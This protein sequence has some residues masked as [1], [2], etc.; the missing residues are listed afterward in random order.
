MTTPIRVLIDGASLGYGIEAGHGRAGTF[1]VADAFVR[2]ALAHPGLRVEVTATDSFFREAQLLR[3][4][5][6]ERAGLG[7]R[8]RRGWQ[9]PSISHEDLAAWIDRVVEVGETTSEGRKLMAQVALAN[10]L[11][12]P[13]RLAC[14]L[15]VYYSLRGPLSRRARGA[16]EACVLLVHDVI[17]LLH[18]EWCADGA[19]DAMRAALASVDCERDW[20]I[21][22]SECTRRD[23]IAL[24]G[25]DASRTFVVPWAA[26]PAVFHPV[27]DPAAIADVRRRHGIGDRPYVLSLSTIEPRKNLDHLLRCFARLVQQPA[28]S[29]LQLVLAGSLGWKTE[30]TRAACDEVNLGDR[31]RW[32]GFVPDADLAALYAGAEVFVCASRYEGFGL[33]VLEAMMCGVPV[34][35][36]DGGSLSE[37]IGDTS[38]AVDPDDADELVA[39]IGAAIGDTDRAAA[40]LAR[41]A[42]FTWE[43]TLD[44]TVAAFDAMLPRW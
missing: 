44:L 43:R 2:R 29:D 38:V 27:T 15:G 36:T 8:L 32:L 16:A 37:V 13:I 31:I 10:R 3:Y 34:V 26:D 23:V 12:Q 18:P 42:S 11:A 33:P 20:I 6:N 39:A 7:H 24:L 21:C 25:I 19:D 28:H 5:R 40:Q 17:P 30:A 35:A 1:R 22:P 9:H 14:W 4:D 41:A